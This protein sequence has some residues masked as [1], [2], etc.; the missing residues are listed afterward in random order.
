LFFELKRLTIQPLTLTPGQ[1]RHLHIC[2]HLRF[3]PVVRPSLAKASAD[4]P[5][6]AKASADR[7]SFAKASADR[8]GIFLF[9]HLHIGTLAAS[10]A[11]KPFFF[12]P[13]QYIEG[14]KR[15]ID[16]RDVLLQV[17]LILIR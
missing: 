8:Q 9:A 16:P 11:H 7:P 4:R 14:G 3:A 1:A 6:F 2:T 13:E 10:L 12:I 15:A 17:H 5:S